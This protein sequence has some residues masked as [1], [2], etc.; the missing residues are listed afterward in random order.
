M[1]AEGTRA[2]SR[3]AAMDWT[4]S[5]LGLS[6]APDSLVGRLLALGRDSRG[7]QDAVADILR[8]VPPGEQLARCKDRR[9]LEV[10]L[11]LCEAQLL[12]YPGETRGVCLLLRATARLQ[13]PAL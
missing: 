9:V 2:Q 8:A 5:A 6:A 3:G 13:P 12:P 4:L 10:M 1:P 11:S 7:W